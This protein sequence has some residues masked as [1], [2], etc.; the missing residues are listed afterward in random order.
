M[1]VASAKIKKEKKKP[2]KWKWYVTV[3]ALTVL[4]SA[5]FSYASSTLLENSGMLIAFAL[6]FGIVLVGVLFDMVGIAVASADE[7]PFHAMASKKVRGAD[8]AIW[9]LRN[10]D[11]VSSFCNDVVGDICGIVSGA[12]SAVI[13]A[14]IIANFSLTAS[15]LVQ[16]VMSAMVAGFTVGGKAVGKSVAMRECT[17]IVFAAGRCLSVFS[18]KKKK[19]RNKGSK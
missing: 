2:R 9:L 7:K 12:A 11:K 3:I 10:A 6:L 4:I 5:G 18:A 8:K 16:L 14:Q 17:K 15:N 13:A 19:K 1:E